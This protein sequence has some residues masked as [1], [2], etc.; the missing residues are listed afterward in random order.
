MRATVWESP[1]GAD[2]GHCDGGI[3]WF[4]PPHRPPHRA[5]CSVPSSHRGLVE[6]DRGRGRVR[7]GR[8]SFKA[9][10]PWPSAGATSSGPVG[11][12][13]NAGEVSAQRNRMVETWAMSSQG[14]EAQRRSPDAGGS[15]DYISW[16]CTKSQR[17]SRSRRLRFRWLVTRR[18][19]G[20]S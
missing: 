2:F 8:R 11:Q 10:W 5:Q 6:I 17:T 3:P 7:C 19:R 12:A 4:R 15:S 9:M 1:G 20:Y 13:P 14:A 16:T 18:R